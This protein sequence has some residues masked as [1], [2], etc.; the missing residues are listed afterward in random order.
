MKMI[1]YVIKLDLQGERS[2]SLSFQLN[3]VD[4]NGEGKDGDIIRRCNSKE[5]MEKF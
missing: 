2:I 4:C 3:N 5:M 1:W